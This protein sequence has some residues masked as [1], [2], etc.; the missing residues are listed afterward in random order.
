MGFPKL[1]RNLRSGHF[2]PTLRPNISCEGLEGRRLLS[3][4]T[5]TAS[6]F[7][8]MESRW[9]EMAPALQRMG[10]AGEFITNLGGG[11]ARS[12]VDFTP[13]SASFGSDA[14]AAITTLSTS[15][16]PN[17]PATAA[18]GQ[19]LVADAGGT[20]ATNAS[21]ATGAEPGAVMVGTGSGMTQ[22]AN[23]SSAGSSTAISVMNMLPVGAAAQYGGGPVMIASG[24]GGPMI[25]STSSN[26]TLPVTEFGVGG[27]T[28]QFVSGGS[29]GP[30]TI[31]PVTIS[32]MGALPGGL[33]VTS[34][35]QTSQAVNE[36]TAGSTAGATVVNA[37]TG[38]IRGI[39]ERVSL[40]EPMQAASG[41]AATSSG[42]STGPGWWAVPSS[43]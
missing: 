1:A 37:T 29:D 33:Q 39:A 26:S 7:G 34:A 27:A 2:R 21:S 43:G 20:L 11:N 24:S 12:N 3:T 4:A 18:L 14:G 41:T 35:S 40:N 13:G 42:V 38:T 10:G 19:A 30:S 23:A 8:G 16:I 28:A 25:V 6:A 9:V 22:A 5:L 36:A 17:E 15:T 31:M 32:S